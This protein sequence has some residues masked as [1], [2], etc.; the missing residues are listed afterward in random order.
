MSGRNDKDGITGTPPDWVVEEMRSLR[1][2]LKE[3]TFKFMTAQ[4]VILAYHAEHVAQ[5]RLHL[6]S[7]PGCGCKVCRLAV[8]IIANDPGKEVGDGG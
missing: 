6:G 7:G 4:K 8:K 5:P 3:A 2:M 1:D